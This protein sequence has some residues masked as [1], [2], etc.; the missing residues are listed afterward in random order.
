[1]SWLDL[2]A[3]GFFVVIAGGFCSY[4]ALTAAAI[5]RVSEPAASGMT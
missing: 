1:V 2:G 3:S 5:G 4:A